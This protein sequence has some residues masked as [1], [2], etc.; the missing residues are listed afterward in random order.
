MDDTVAAAVAAQPSLPFRP[1]LPLVGAPGAN[2]LGPLPAAVA[3][4]GV[5]HAPLMVLRF[6]DDR[7]SPQERLDAARD[8][9]ASQPCRREQ[10]D[11][12]TIERCGLFVSVEAPGRYHSTLTYDAARVGGQAVQ[13]VV[14]FLDQHLR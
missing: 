6:R 11:L 10:Q 13:A 8:R 2:N 9:F 12:L 5:G 1:R 7:I 3:N 14:S 4:G